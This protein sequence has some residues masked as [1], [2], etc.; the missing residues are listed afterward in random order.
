MR[1]VFQH[2]LDPDLARRAAD[3]AFQTYCERYARYEPRV[4]WD[5]DLKARCSF[6]AKGLR[7]FATL[8]LRPREILVEI[9]VPL[10]LRPFRALALERVERDLRLWCDRARRGEL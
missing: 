7:I 9:E 1:H 6:K 2:D 3:R 10:L 4:L 8:E 5:G